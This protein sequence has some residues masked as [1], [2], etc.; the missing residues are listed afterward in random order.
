MDLRTELGPEVR[1]VE[2]IRQIAGVPRPAPMQAI[3]DSYRD[4]IVFD[5]PLNTPDGVALGGHH[6]ITLERDGRVHHEGQHER[7]FATAVFGPTLPFD[8]IRLT[9]M[10]GLNGRAFTMPSSPPPTSTTCRTP[11]KS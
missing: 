11:V 5:E 10:L 6:R 8:R 3:L 7:D 4:P 9:N 1:S 2:A